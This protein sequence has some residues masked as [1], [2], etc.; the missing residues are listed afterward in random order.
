[1]TATNDFAVDRDDLER[2][3]EIARELVKRKQGRVIDFMFPEKD[4]KIIPGVFPHGHKLFEDPDDSGDGSK[5]FIVH[6][7]SKYKKHLEFFNSGSKYPIRLFQAGNRIGKTTAAGVELV[8]H[9][10]GDYPDW[11]DGKR[12]TTCRDWWVVGK[13]SETVKGIL[14]PLLLGTVG[15]FGSGLVPRDRLDL[16]TLTDA[17]K[18]STGVS[19][20]RVKHKNGT[21]STVE[22]KSFDQGRQAFEG[23]ARSVWLDE[24]PPKP[25]FSECLLRTMTGGNIV[26]MTFTPLKG[27]SD[28]VK[29]FYPDG[30]VTAEGDVGA[31]R[32]IVRV[33][34][35]EVPHI[36]PEKKEI[37][38]AREL[39]HERKAREFGIPFLGSGAI[40]PVNE[41]SVIIEPFEIPKHWQKGYGLDV[42]RNTGGA[43][44]ARN[45]DTGELFT[46]S[47]L[48]MV[49]GTP[50]NHVDS[51][52]ARGKW[53][54]GAIDTSAR[55]R[56]QTD[57]ENLFDIYREKGL[58][59]VN[60]DKAVSAG[61]YEVLELLISGRLKIFNTCTELIK[62]FRGY[63]RNEKGEIIKKN[64]HIMDAWR[65]AIFNRDKIMRTEAEF[66]AYNEPVLVPY[67]E[68]PYADDGWAV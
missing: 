1:M 46:Y 44:I 60:A 51:I 66:K 40:Y 57:G 32:Y 34:M 59:L 45:P 19:S 67:E 35:N 31:G 12:F 29:D 54:K 5:P 9:L 13:T 65:Y 39:P 3:V 37:L 49:E 22:F 25:V 41:D 17:K 24:E 2:M 11:W 48:K 33:S 8:Y 15:N 7:L 61:L 42:G 53:L 4:I 36:T 63:Q 23:T 6:S 30:D 55:G 14:Q 62:E 56:S 16:E 28:V 50:S 20:F 10:T 43:W 38:L 26:M 52:Q 21:Y 58:H 47:D 27:A 68:V 18:T 64:D